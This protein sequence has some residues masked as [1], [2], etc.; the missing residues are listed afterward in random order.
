MMLHETC[1]IMSFNNNERCCFY[2]KQVIRRAK[3]LVNYPV[4][5]RGYTRRYTRDIQGDTQGIYKGIYKG[6]YMGIQKEIYK[7]IH[8]HL[9]FGG[10]IAA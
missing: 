7:G 8:V 1:E 3:F 6:L 4:L 9:D 10:L 2:I 5:A